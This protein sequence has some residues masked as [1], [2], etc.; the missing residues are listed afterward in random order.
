MNTADFAYDT[1]STCVG[2]PQRVTI[3]G[4]GS[5][6]RGELASDLAGAGFRIFDGGELAALLDGPLALASDVVMVDCPSLDPAAMAG[7][8]FLDECAAH[9]GTR[10]IVSTSL[11]SLDAVFGLL[12]LS[13]PQIL[14]AP[15]RA[16]RVLAVGRAC[17]EAGSAR[18]R[19]MD[20]A[21]RLT[22]L[23]LSQQVDAIARTIDR[24]SGSKVAWGG[25]DNERSTSLRDP[26]PAFRRPEHSGSFHAGPASQAELPDPKLIRQIIANRQRRTRFF[27]AELF[28]D[29]AW[30][31]LLDLAAAHGE[32]QR[33][34]VTSLCI[35]ANVPTTTALR[36]LTQMVESGVFCRVADP[37][38]KRR[39][40]I[41]LSD[42][43]I[44]AMARYFASIKEPLACHA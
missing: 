2:A 16:E 20:E 1:S 36:W 21:E 3:F 13:A 17:G 34:S 11:G 27:A 29:P 24:I 22:L 6:L 14:V 12:H 37:I 38:D 26:K 31:M 9:K 23:Q 43:A 30:D 4:A 44:T 39:A 7:L 19:E 40:F 41:E 33:V 25:A 35:A 5:A 42:N 28:A 15:S 8:A 32:G 10:L 18:L